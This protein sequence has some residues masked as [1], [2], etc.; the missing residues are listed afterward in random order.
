MIDSLLFEYGNFISLQKTTSLH[1]SCIETEVN[2]VNYI[3]K[4]VPIIKTSQQFTCLLASFLL[5]IALDSDVFMSVGN[6][7]PSIPP[8][9]EKDPS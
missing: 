3:K 5:K 8:L 6:E 7:F 4:Y 9:Y 1:E 2:T